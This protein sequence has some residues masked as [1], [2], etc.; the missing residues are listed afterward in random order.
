MKTAFME[1]SLITWSRYFHQEVKK[2]ELLLV[3]STQFMLDDRV[4]AFWL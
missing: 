3:P 1:Q 2:M 4:A